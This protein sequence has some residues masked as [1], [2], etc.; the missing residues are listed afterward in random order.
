MCIVDPNF[1]ISN[2][3]E[4]KYLAWQSKKLIMIASVIFSSAFDLLRID[5]HGFNMFCKH[6]VTKYP[7]YFISPLRTTGSAVE[8]LFSQYKYSA[9]GKL[10]AA[11]YSYS[12]AVSLV[13]QVTTTHHSGEDY[14]DGELAVPSLPLSKKQYN[15][16]S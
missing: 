4:K 6:F 16:M 7:G 3:N 15:K 8:T 10:D 2:S 9:G 5:I 11:N 12:R 13:K 1:Q 14:R